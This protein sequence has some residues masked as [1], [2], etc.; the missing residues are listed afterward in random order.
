MKIFR[1][2]NCRTPYSLASSLTDGV[3]ILVKCVQC[4]AE[5][6]VRFSPYLEVASKNRKKIQIVIKPGKNM[7]GRTVGN[8]DDL[9]D[10]FVSREHALVWATLQDGKWFFSIEDCNSSNGT[11]DMEKNRLQP[12]QKYPFPPGA[13]YIIGLTKLTMKVPV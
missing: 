3:A 1:C 10:G 13:S 9:M 12:G 2:G 4:N 6:T 11:F 8:L 5:N 7:V